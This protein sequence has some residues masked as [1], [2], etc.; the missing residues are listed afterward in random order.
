MTFSLFNVFKL[1]MAADRNW[2]RK[3]EIGCRPFY[4]PAENC[5]FLIHFPHNSQNENFNLMEIYYWLNAKTV[6]YLL[7]FLEQTTAI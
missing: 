2:K 6:E 7:K 5:D 4:E 3:D 1:K